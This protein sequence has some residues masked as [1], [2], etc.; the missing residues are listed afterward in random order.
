MEETI[1]NTNT[2]ETT[3]QKKYIDEEQLEQLWKKMQ[4]ME[5]RIDSIDKEVQE[6][7]KI[8]TRQRRYSQ[9][10]TGNNRKA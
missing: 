3:I 7:K 1:K 6:L 9:H 10:S 2:P 4:K 8:I 5:E